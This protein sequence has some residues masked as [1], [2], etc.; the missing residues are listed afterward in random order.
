M[1]PHGTKP[2]TATTAISFA[3]G[4]EVQD[5]GVHET[6]LRGS[7]LS[8]DNCRAGVSGR[9]GGRKAGE[10]RAQGIRV[11][12]AAARYQSASRPVRHQTGGSEE[13]PRDCGLRSLQPRELSPAA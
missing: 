9:R 10:N 3:R 5:Y 6:E 13:S 4:A 12:S 2:T 8:G 1:S 7:R 11:P